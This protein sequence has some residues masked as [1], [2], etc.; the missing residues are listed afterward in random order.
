MDGTVF[1][2]QETTPNDPRIPF[3]GRCIR[4]IRAYAACFLLFFRC[5]PVCMTVCMGFAYAILLITVVIVCKWRAY[6]R[7]Y[8]IL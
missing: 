4:R 5:M 6:A 3:G 1:V 8:V 2:F 7:A